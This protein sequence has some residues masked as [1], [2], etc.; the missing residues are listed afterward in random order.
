MRVL[1]IVTSEHI[2]NP[3]FLIIEIDAF[4]SLLQVAYLQVQT[5]YIHK[6]QVICLLIVINQIWTM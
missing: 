6:L 5:K 1:E 4:I 2:T 3:S